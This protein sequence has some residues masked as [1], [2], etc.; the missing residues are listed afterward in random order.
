M[1]QYFLI[2]GGKS[3]NGEIDVC[4][5]KNATTP[6]IA[7]SLLTKEKSIISNLPLIEDVFNMLRILESMNVKVRWI[8]ER[9]VE[10]D[11]KNLNLDNV[12]QKLIKKLRSSVLLIAPLCHH[13]KKFSLA[14]PGG[15][16]IG[17]RPI[18]AHLEAIKQFGAKVKIT[19]D[20]YIFSCENLSAQEI[21]LKE[22]SVTATENILMLA[23]VLPGK[24]IIK[25]AAIEPHVLDL[26][27][28]LQGMGAD[29]KELPG[30]IFEISGK[31]S[32]MGNSKHT[33]IPDPVEAGTFIIMAITCHGRVN[34]NNVRIDHLDLV[35]RKLEEFGAKFEFSLQN[36]KENL[37]TVKVKPILHLN[38]IS[39]IQALP[40]PGIPTDLQSMFGVLATQA[41]GTTIIHDPM[42]E[43]RLRYI[44]ELN[45]MGAN[46]IIADPHRALISGPTPLYGR[47]IT[48]FD[49]RTGAC[50]IVA[51]LLAKEQTKIGDI[52]QV[53]R[54]YEKIEERLTKLG[55]NIKRIEE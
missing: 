27:K 2:K 11:P 43:G 5:S 1:G 45:K 7:A 31:K 6:I 37:Y 29:I 19:S 14:Q 51:A 39:K 54:G 12:N 18:D 30:H 55:A 41:D 52:Y 21:V 53:D 42:Y 34:I 35:F 28:F 24:S 38:A 40:Y 16:L 44:D 47:D 26:V 22:F 15:C 3:L 48:S 32:L 23:S 50:L 49:L 46:A 33:I 4:G 10:I 20:K 9:T 13:F 8:N 25:I 17:A 36:K